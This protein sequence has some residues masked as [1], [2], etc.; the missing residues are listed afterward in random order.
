MIKQDLMTLEEL[1]EYLPDK[2]RPITIYRYVCDGVIP[3][4]KY[5]KKLFFSKAEID[6]WNLKGRRK[7]YA[8]KQIIP[9]I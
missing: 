1:R 9:A 2:P 8:K 7:A 6:E 5:G 3:Y 4:Y